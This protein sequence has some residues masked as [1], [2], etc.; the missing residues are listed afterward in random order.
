MVDRFNN[1]LAPRHLPFDGPN[2]MQATL[3][4]LEV[5]ILGR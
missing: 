4:P 3:A 5:Q 1:S 2:C